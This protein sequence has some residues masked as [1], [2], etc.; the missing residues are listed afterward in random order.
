MSFEFEQEDQAKNCISNVSSLYKKL[1][2]TQKRHTKKTETTSKAEDEIN[3]VQV[4]LPSAKEEP[5]SK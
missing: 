4:S 1:K 3:S 5:R 2:N